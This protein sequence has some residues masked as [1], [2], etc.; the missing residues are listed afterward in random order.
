MNQVAQSVGAAGTSF[1]KLT[2]QIQGAT[3]Q[4]TAIGTPISKVSSSVT[5]FGKAT[6]IAG[7]KTASFGQK[8]ADN[9]GIVFGVAGLSSAM[10]EAVGMMGMFGDTQDRLREAQEKLNMVRESGAKGG[11]ELAEAEAEVAKQSRFANMVTR[12]TALSMMD[13]VFFLTMVVS[14]LQKSGIGFSKLKGIVTGMPAIFQKFGAATQTV[15]GALPSI[16]IGATKAGTSLGTFSKGLNSMNTLAPMA[17][18][19][20]TKLSTALKFAGVVAAV[21]GAIALIVTAI[22]KTTEL[23]AAVHQTFGAATVDLS[24]WEQQVIRTKM[25]FGTATAEE[26]AN[27][28]QFESQTEI[29]NQAMMELKVSPWDMWFSEEKK[30]AVLKRMQEIIDKNNDTK[31]EIAAKNKTTWIEEYNKGIL[32][33]VNNTKKATPIA[34][35]LSN[36]I[37]ASSLPLEQELQNMEATVDAMVARNAVTKETG[38]EIKRL[39]HIGW[40]PLLKKEEEVKESILSVRD[41]MNVLSASEFG[42]AEMID[43][44]PFGDNFGDTLAKAKS[45]IAQFTRDAKVLFDAYNQAVAEDASVTPEMILSGYEEMAPEVK[46][47]FLDMVKDQEDAVDKVIETGEELLDLIKETVAEYDALAAEVGKYVDVT[48]MSFDQMEDMRDIHNE[49][50]GVIQ[51]Q[52]EKLRDSAEHWK[53]MTVEEIKTTQADAQYAFQIANTNDMI[54]TNIEWQFK[55]MK[56][57][58]D[59]ATAAKAQS[60]A[61]RLG[62]VE[63]EQFRTTFIG[64]NDQFLTG[65]PLMRMTTDEIVAYTQAQQDSTDATI[66]AQRAL[67][68]FH[69]GAVQALSGLFDAENNKEFKDAWKELDLGSIPKNLKDDFKGIAKEM[70]PAF[71]RGREVSTAL[72]LIAISGDK[73]KGKKLNETFKEIAKDFKKFAQVDLEANDLLT[74]A[75]NIFNDIAK[76]GDKFKRVQIAITEAMR[77]NDISAEELVKILAEYG[78]ATGKN[79]DETKKGTDALGQFSDEM[80]QVEANAIVVESIKG[81]WTDM[82]T[83]MM[84]QNELL[85]G[86]WTLQMLSVEIDAAIAAAQTRDF[87]SEMV[88][89]TGSNMSELSEHWADMCK[90][91]SAEGEQSGQDIES[92]FSDMVSNVGKNMSELSEHWA[93]MCNNMVSEAESAASDIESEL[94][95]IPDEEVRINIRKVYVNSEGGIYS[96]A[97]GA[98]IS[99]KSGLTTSNGPTYL[100]GD[101]S[102]GR[103][104]IAFLPHDAHKADR[105]MDMLD[106]QFGRRKNMTVVTGGGDREITVPIN[107]YIDGQA[108]SFQQKYRIRQGQDI[109]QQVF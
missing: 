32:D 59:G 52:A 74:Q 83:V 58:L 77:D 15:G 29:M 43:F 73:I 99:A 67:S 18:S 97:E 27:L 46:Q 10:A 7:K 31:E 106:Q 17:A 48:G 89:E 14:G 23:S 11:R 69:S 61:I 33:M 2:P 41:T 3:S 84:E 82:V 35:G 95:S 19:G 86:Q 39:V 64:L 98:V 71:E 60:E 16:S 42:R 91:M 22:Q 70:R 25:T 26:I 62:T 56:A 51:A 50:T 66:E 37:Q 79:T 53:K 104:T 21:A 100:Y 96:A 75:P 87:F 54:S 34:L 55:N 6:D 109:A 63:S 101:N 44:D 92:A 93:D 80:A 9:R 76:G 68:E 5:D 4:L 45:K 13:N 78:K 8:F 49:T 72:D 81:M 30:Q 47:I 24:L 94:G 65:A 40:D 1:Q 107:I 102:G 36:A 90:N 88:T 38:E 103:E 57:Q 20:I 105:I 28:K 12:N 85:A 108:Y